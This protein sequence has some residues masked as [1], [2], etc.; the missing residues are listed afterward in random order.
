MT[1]NVLLYNDNLLY[2]S[3]PFMQT[4]QA[5]ADESFIR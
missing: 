1:I 3:D 2:I 5:F 4:H